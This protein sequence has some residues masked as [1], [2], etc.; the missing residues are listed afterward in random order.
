MRVVRDRWATTALVAATAVGALPFLAIGVLGLGA[1]GL[2]LSLVGLLY[3]ATVGLALRPIRIHP[4]ADL[5]PSDVAILAAVILLPPGGASLVAALGRITNDLL[6][7]KRTEQIVRNAGAVAI[8][9]GMASLV[10]AIVWSTSMGIVGLVA[11]VPAAV[12][13][14]L[15]LVGTDLAQLYLLLLALRAPMVD[16]GLHWVARTGRAQLL[17]GLAAVITIEVI[18]IEPWFL[19]PGFPLFLFGYLDIRARFVAERRARLL[20]TLVEVGHAVGMSVDT[21]EVFRAVYKQVHSVLE[22]DAFFVA[23]VDRARATVSYRFLVDGDSELAPVDKPAA[24]TLAGFVVQSD[25]PLLVRNVERDFRELGITRS[26]F[27]RTQERSILV[28]PLRIRSTVIGALSV[29]SVKPDAYD[30]GDL[31]LLGA[32]A[33]EAAIAIERADLY[34]RASGLSTRLVELHRTGVELASQRRLQD[35]TELLAKAFVTSIGASAA[36]VYLDTGGETLEFASNSG[37]RRPA[38]LVLQKATSG[39]DTALTRGIPIEVPDAE[40]VPDPMRSQ[41]REHGH[42][43]LFVQPLRAASESIGV[44]FITWPAA[45]I[46]SDDER[47]LIGVLAGMGATAI[48]SMR[49]YTE[50]DDAYLSTVSRLTAMIQARD[51]YQEDHQRRVAADAVALGKRLG[52]NDERLRDLR[53]ASLFHSLGKIGV[54]AAVLAKSAP[55]TPDERRMVQEHPLLGA[56]IL[57]SIQFLRDVVP[58]VR[59]ANERWD[60]SGYPGGLAGEAIPLSARVLAVAISYEAM[61]AARPYRVAIGAE[62]AVAELRQL[63]GKWYDP[64]VVREFVAMIEGRGAVAAAEEEIGAGSRELAILAEITPE[65]H[66]LLDM[67]Q[68]LARI[69]GILERHMPGSSFTILLREE[70]TGDLVVRAAAGRQIDLAGPTRVP[71]GRGLSG[72]VVEHGESQIVDDV[73]G[74]PRYV[75]DPS[76]RAEMVVPLLSSGR[77]IGVLVLSHASVGVYGQ[78]D[79]TLLQAVAAQIA[80]AIDVAEL[81]ERLTRAANSDAL[82]GIHNYG[83]FYGRLEEEVARAER[84]ATP[85]AV[86]YFDIDGLKRV[87]D[88]YGHLAG[89]A[90]LRELGHTIGRRVRAEDVPARYGGDEFAIVMPETPRDEAEKVVQRLMDE[91]DACVVELPDATTIPMPARSWGI[92]SY[93]LDG[94]TAKALVENADTRAYARKRAH[95]EIAR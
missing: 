12:A 17:W 84:R 43:A 54:P 64:G 86:A 68:L 48:R 55:L 5:S 39:I 13:A 15:V 88:T 58:I 91:L 40:R 37:G 51:G 95:S 66:T 32:I 1:A 30:G 82:T 11:S 56:R 18:I 78:R 85:L 74:D 8:S 52:F 81:H 73:R 31:E 38:E 42:G 41:L 65:F 59:H 90:V 79:L 92:A 49:L 27:G 61:L 67:Q 76:V 69:L 72:W 75:G 24:D 4:D 62:A 22:S 83:Y 63:A 46:F 87:N 45:H 34:E 94:K 23:I 44:L 2:E 57:E 29:Q 33:N 80:A 9:S 89:D 14:V 10:Y 70:S 25:Q 77:T 93:P 16:R 7:R 60:G 21:T 50:L 26:A 36:A 28:T 6:A 19:V 20:A 53:Y 3:L 35:V 47:E 71:T